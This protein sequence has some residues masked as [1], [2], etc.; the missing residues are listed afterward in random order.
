VGRPDSTDWLAR[1]PLASTLR[2]SPLGREDALA[3]AEAMCPTLPPGAHLLVDRSA[4]NPLYLRELLRSQR[5]VGL[6]LPPSL[7][8][9]VAARLD[10]LPPGEKAALQHVAVLGEAAT[11]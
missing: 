5:G 11:V 10:A 3:L 9:V 7:R 2:L 8:A 6:A 4:G 1:F